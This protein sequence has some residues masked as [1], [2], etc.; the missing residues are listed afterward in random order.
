MKVE[1]GSSFS[2]VPLTDLFTRH[3]KSVIM[4]FTEAVRS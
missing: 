2:L 1:L 4:F 3:Q